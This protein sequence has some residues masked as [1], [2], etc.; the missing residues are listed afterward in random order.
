M[1]NSFPPNPPAPRMRPST[2]RRW[3]TAGLLLAT[4]CAASAQT[5]ARPGWSA[6]GFNADPWWKR[7]VFYEIK[8]GDQASP[9]ALGEV[10]PKTIAANL[11]S[12]KSLGIDALILPMPASPKPN[13][14]LDSFDDLIRQ[15][16]NRGIHILLTLPAASVNADLS[17]TA[18]F[19]ISR[20]VSGFHL[21][22]PPA[23][24][25]Q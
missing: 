9:N 12:V 2:R 1:P 3:L 16:S 15:S 25:T 21:V 14:T 17:A 4:V 22:T 20:G 19:W 23:T 7:A 6:S 24:S 13:A 11:D 10:D 5:L 18:R 8:E